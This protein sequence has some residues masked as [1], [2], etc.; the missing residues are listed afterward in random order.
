MRRP[1]LAALA[2]LALLVLSGAAQAHLV[3]SGLGP[4][5][6]GAL[7]LLLSPAGLLGLAA[8]ALLAGLRGREAARLTVITVPIA[9]LLGGFIGMVL[10][11]TL[12]LAWPSAVS[13]I[14]LGALVATDAAIPTVPIAALGGLHA[15][16]HGLSDGSALM[17]AGAGG[18]SLLGVMLAALLT[19]LLISALVVSLRRFWARVAVR[20]AG[21][22]IVAVG[23]L[24]LGWLSHG[25][26]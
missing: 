21:S 25:V 19:A 13:L 7:H 9:W 6:D 1:G 4:F 26:A 18:V 2:V 16:L 10:P 20:V 8:A 12:D 23:M 17:A 24:M 11:V 15:G 14:V 5:Y 3:T 22:W